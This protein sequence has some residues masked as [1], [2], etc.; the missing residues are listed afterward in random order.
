[1]NENR[2]AVPAVLGQMEPT[3]GQVTEPL[4]G[5]KEFTRNARASIMEG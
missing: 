2:D 1:M 4:Y 3:L 5:G